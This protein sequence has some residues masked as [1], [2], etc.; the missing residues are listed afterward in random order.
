MGSLSVKLDQTKSRLEQKEEIA[1]NDDNSASDALEKANRAQIKA[2]EASM[3]VEKAKKELEDISAILSTVQDPEPGLL[4]A[5]QRRVE[6]AERTYKAAE[7]DERLNEF[8]AARKRQAEQM[9]D[10]QREL[11]YVRLELSSLSEIERS[12]PRECWNTIRL[13]P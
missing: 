6:A 2:Q 13:E 7:L 12:L 8:E 1:A 11:E 4:Q 5:L 3:K 9:R 10:L